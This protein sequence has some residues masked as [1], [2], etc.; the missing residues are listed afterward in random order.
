MTDPIQQLEDRGYTVAV[1]NGPTPADERQRL[2]LQDDSNAPCVYRVEGFGLSTHVTLDDS[3]AITSL[4]GSR[5]QELSLQTVDDLQSIATSLDI[6]GRAAL[7]KDDLVVAIQA[8]E[9]AS[10][11]DAPTTIRSR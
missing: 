5:I 10:T 11:T 6:S 1:A 3:D 8:A 7:R 4:L 2:Q 9:D